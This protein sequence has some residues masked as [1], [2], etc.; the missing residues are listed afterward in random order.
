MTNKTKKQHA[1]KNR[2]HNFT[3]LASFCFPW[4]KQQNEQR[5]KF[6]LK[7]WNRMK[8]CSL[9]IFLLWV[10]SLKV[11]VYIASHA[12]TVPSI[13]TLYHS[14]KSALQVTR[15]EKLKFETCANSQISKCMNDLDLTTTHELNRAQISSQHNSKIVEKV[16]KIAEECESDYNDLR[17]ALDTLTSFHPRL[18]QFQNDTC[19]AEEKDI[20]MNSAISVDTFKSE[21]F[22][23]AAEFEQT[24][25]S[26]MNN[27]IKYAKIRAEYDTN[28]IK[29]HISKSMQFLDL[30]FQVPPLDIS[31]EIEQVMSSVGNW[32]G[33]MSISRRAPCISLDGMI[34]SHELLL[35]FHIDAKTKATELLEKSR[36]AYNEKYN[37][38][39]EMHQN[40]MEKASNWVELFIGKTIRAPVDFFHHTLFKYL[41]YIV[42]P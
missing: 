37:H 23:V 24:S 31:G 41:V 36:N 20:L 10:S 22:L 28:Y 17:N 40:I 32:A 27:I 9:A 13:T 35:D 42:Q 39:V 4:F 18:L 14:C 16:E 19:S 11:A 6:D 12:I 5:H 15:D 34:P 38:I 25:Q 29:K 26:T 8:L 1:K 30:N 21:A 3:N 33:C 2:K 7:L